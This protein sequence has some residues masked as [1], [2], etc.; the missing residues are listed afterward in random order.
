MSL[1]NCVRPG[2]RVEI[3]GVMRDDP[4][5][6]QIGDRGTVTRINPSSRLEPIQY[7]VDWDN[8]RS[9]ILLSIDPFKVV[10]WEEP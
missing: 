10:T 7:F 5:P 9:L 6:M 1:L 2:D 3:T 4:A 8:G